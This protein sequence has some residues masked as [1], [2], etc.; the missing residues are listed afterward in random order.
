MK[1]RSNIRALPLACV[2]LTIASCQDS[3]LRSENALLRERVYRLER[4]VDSLK[5]IVADQNLPIKKKSSKKT[6]DAFKKTDASSVSQTYQ[7][8]SSP[9]KTSSNN[10]VLY[11]VRCQAITKKGTQCK[12]TARSGG[13]CWQHGG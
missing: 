13:Y 5:S 2:I 4:E 6:V 11:S 7:A 12:R 1:I 10:T 3:S 8:N 9:S